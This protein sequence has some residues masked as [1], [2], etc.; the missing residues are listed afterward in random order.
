MAEQRQSR[1]TAVG[2]VYDELAVVNRRAAVRARSGA[3]PLT[4]VE[5]ALLDLVGASP[6]ITAADLARVLQL[7]RST[8]SRQLADL[9]RAGHVAVQR[10]SPGRAQALR[11]TEA[12]ERALAASRAAHLDSL[13]ARMD[14]WST[15]EIAAFA[16]VLATFNRGR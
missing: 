3:S 1:S 8:T 4:L 2:R 16:E 12:G 13:E 9:M 11:L 7:N 14:T 10:D 6:G 15:D 5:H